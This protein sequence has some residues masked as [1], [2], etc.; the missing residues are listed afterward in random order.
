[1]PA[2]NQNSSATTP[3]ETYKPDE[4]QSFGA[5]SFSI[6]KGWTTVTP[7]RDKTKAMILLEGTDWQNAKAM[8][9]IDVGM[10]AAPTARQLAESFAKNTGGSVSTDTLDFDGEPGVIASTSSNELTTPRNM[11]VLYRE[12]KAYLLMVGA[13]AG[14]DVGDAVSH[15]RETWKWN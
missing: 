7:D 15:V 6:P 2:G 13:T 9:K 10:P 14:V 5:F 4:S 1:M 12:G 8:I 11:I 3:A